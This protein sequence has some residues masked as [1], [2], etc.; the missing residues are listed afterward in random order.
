MMKRKL[1]IASLALLALAAGI[2]LFMAGGRAPRMDH[3]GHSA[4]QMSAS[5][6]REGGQASFAAIQEIVAQLMADPGTDWRH[7]DIAALRQHLID[8][9]NVT[10]RAQVAVQDIDG[11]ARFLV[12]SASPEVTASIRRM[13]LAHAAAM[14]GVSGMRMDAAESPDGARLDITGPNPEMIR[15]LG[16]IGLMTVGMHHQ[17]HHLA[18]ARGEN[19]HAH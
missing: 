5:G 9:D 17:A 14:T 3:A 15:A 2:A 16:F 8:M 10:L 18:L 7:V 6:I 19:P 4:G 12:T 13:T 11:G 1:M